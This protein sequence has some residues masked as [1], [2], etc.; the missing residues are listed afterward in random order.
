MVDFCSV[1][2]RVKMEACEDL[3]PMCD[4]S[5]LGKCMTG[6]VA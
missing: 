6:N 3:V 4:H 1:V 2:S 5:D